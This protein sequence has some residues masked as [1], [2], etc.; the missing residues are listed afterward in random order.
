M[1]WRFWRKKHIGV[2]PRVG[3]FDVFRLSE[4]FRG[5]LALNSAEYLLR[6]VLL[7][8]NPPSSV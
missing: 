5:T 7:I 6:F 1:S 2:G 8:G 3:L 4:G